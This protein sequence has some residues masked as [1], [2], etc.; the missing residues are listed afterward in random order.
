MVPLDATL[1]VAGMHCG[2]CAAALE[3]AL[4]KLPG[5]MSARV[6]FA[7]SQAWLQLA[8][9]NAL[10]AA[11]EAVTGLGFTTDTAVTAPVAAPPAAAGQSRGAA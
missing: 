2:G 3:G 8:D 7:R 9:A 5:V 10:S 1:A 11:R 6:D 4:A